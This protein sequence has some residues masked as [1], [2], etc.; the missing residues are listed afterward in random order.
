MTLATQ[1]EIREVRG[2]TDAQRDGIRAF[3]Q[4]AVYC[5]VKNSSEEWFHVRDLVGGA[6]TDWNG[7]PLQALYEK[8]I[9]AGSA[10][11]EAYEAAA[12]EIGWIVKAVLS[13]DKRIFENDHSGYVSRYRW[14]KANDA[15]GEPPQ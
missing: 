8:H 12:K 14:L 4:G 10:A 1:S 15:R 2:L 6:N 5:W 9:V 7:T 3:V 13:D 11:A